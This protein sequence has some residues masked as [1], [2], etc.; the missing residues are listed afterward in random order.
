MRVKKIQLLF[1]IAFILFF[2]VTLSLHIPDNYNKDYFIYPDATSYTATA[3]SL[4]NNHFT[5]NA[6]R[7]MAGR[8]F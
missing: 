8:L 5:P 2:I 7:P 4:Y 3:F 1:L 6:I